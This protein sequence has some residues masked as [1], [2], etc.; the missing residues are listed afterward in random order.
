[1]QLE[2]KKIQRALLKTPGTD[3]IKVKRNL[4]KKVKTVV[5][6]PADV[7]IN[8]FLTLISFDTGLFK[9]LICSS[10]GMRKHI[11]FELFSRVRQTLFQ[12][13]NKAYGL[14]L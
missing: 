7:P 13:F 4:K 12:G 10:K 11:L 1:M 2:K 14:Y 6:D 5:S 8:I 9:S 3:E